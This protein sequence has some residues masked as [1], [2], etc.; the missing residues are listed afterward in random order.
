MD[1]K[2]Q[3]QKRQEKEMLWTL[4]VQGKQ[5]EDLAREHWWTNKQLQG[6][7]AN[8]SIGVQSDFEKVWFLFY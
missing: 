3:E 4:N 5:L 7:M 1:A 6:M 8:L 2:E